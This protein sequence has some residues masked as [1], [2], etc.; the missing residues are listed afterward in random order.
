[1]KIDV[2]ILEKEKSTLFSSASAFITSF[3]SCLFRV[4]IQLDG[5]V[6]DSQKILNNTSST[7]IAHP[8]KHRI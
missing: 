2:L 1:M 8:E 7:M 4:K 6:S 5:Y 3:H